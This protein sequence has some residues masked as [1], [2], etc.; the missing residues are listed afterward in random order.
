MQTKPA[1]PQLLAWYPDIA[2]GGLLGLLTAAIALS[3][4]L[5]APELGWCLA[6]TMIYTRF[7]TVTHMALNKAWSPRLGRL[8][9]VYAITTTVIFLASTTVLRIDPLIGALLVI[10]TSS[11]VDLFVYSLR[12]AHLKEPD[13]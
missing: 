1:R 6:A 9:T 8:I 10:T 12:K 7:L 11:P 3:R 13:A 2:F 4:G 5:D